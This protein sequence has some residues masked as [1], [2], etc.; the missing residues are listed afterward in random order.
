MVHSVHPKGMSRHQ[1]TLLERA[2]LVLSKLDEGGWQE[3]PLDLRVSFAKYMDAEAWTHM[4]DLLTLREASL[5]ILR[6]AIAHTGE[7]SPEAVD[8]PP[9]ESPPVKA[10][11]AK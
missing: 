3:M 2:L 11:V 4:P 1:L 7:F 5:K 10:L 8:Q 9:D 6:D